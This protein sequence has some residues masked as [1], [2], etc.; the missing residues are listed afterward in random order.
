MRPRIALLAATTA[1]LGTLALAGC[2][3]DPEP[4]PTPT[5]TATADAQAQE[6]VID[7]TDAP[8]TGEGFAGAVADTTV[9]C[10]A[11]DGTWDVSGVVTNPTDAPA[12]YR[13]YVS[14]LNG[15]GDTRALTQVDVP[16]VAPAAPTDWST[17]V[18]L[19]EPD[20]SCVLRV[21]RYGEAGEAPAEG[22]PSPEPTDG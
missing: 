1:V 21:E 12:D 11:G 14:L 15:A 17:S 19:D 8:G 20:L 3:S 16:D 6:A 4:E 5:P 13:I 22:E 2:A 18:E 9:T 10:D 7:V